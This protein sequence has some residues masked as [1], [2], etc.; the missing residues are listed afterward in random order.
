[1]LDLD[2]VEG[3]ATAGTSLRYDGT[4]WVPSAVL[5]PGY[6]GS[7]WDTTDQE[8]DADTA[9][10]VTLNSADPENN[11]VSVVDDSK[12]TVANDGVYNIQFS[13]QLDRT[14]GSGVDEVDV[15]LTKNLE[16]VPDTNTKVTV[17]G[18]ANQAKVVAAWNFVLR[19]EADDF[20]ELYWSSTDANII[21]HHQDAQT[22]PVR[23]AI[24]S[25]IL[26]VTQV[27]A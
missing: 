16:N 27:S 12:I 21:M 9:T 8:I 14:Q 17:S 18:T 24:P 11:G 3:T 6:W 1:L 15:W 26:T 19:L 23:P 13:A 10:A 7:F 20:V 5:S 4:K 2:D 22:G 25:I